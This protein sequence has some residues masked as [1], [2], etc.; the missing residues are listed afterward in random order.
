[1]RLWTRAL[2]SALLALGATQI[3]L[4]DGKS[5]APA[6]L[7]KNVVKEVRYHCEPHPATNDA[8]TC[9]SDRAAHRIASTPLAPAYPTHEKIPSVNLDASES[10]CFTV[11]LDVVR[12]LPTSRAPP[13]LS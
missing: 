10:G 6:R 2:L 11:G 4:H 1:M 5:R 8:R 9:V 12:L 7:A 3:A 13:A